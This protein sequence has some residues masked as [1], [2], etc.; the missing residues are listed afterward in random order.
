[1]ETRGGSIWKK[2][3]PVTGSRWTTDG[4]IRIFTYGFLEGPLIPFLFIVNLCLF[5]LFG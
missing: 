3:H 5:C 1:M 4:F 2:K